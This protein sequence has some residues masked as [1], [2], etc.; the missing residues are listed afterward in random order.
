MLL[1]FEL[2]WLDGWSYIHKQTTVLV[3]ETRGHAHLVYWTNP[4]CHSD[5]KQK[6]NTCYPAPVILDTWTLQNG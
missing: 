1:C 2:D 6:A 5:V 3:Q 4:G